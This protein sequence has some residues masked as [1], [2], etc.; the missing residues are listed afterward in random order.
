MAIRYSA[1]VHEFIRLNYQLYTQEELANAVNEKFGTDFT[2]LKMKSYFSN[3]GLKSQKR[4]SVKSRLY[5]SEVQDF[6]RDNV[7]G[8]HF[9]DLTAAINRFFGTNYKTSQIRAY[10]KNH[11]L[12]NGIDCRIKPGSVPYTKGKTWDEYMD[13]EH[14]AK[15]RQTCY[16]KGHKPANEMKIGD[17]AQTSDGYLIIKVSNV[18]SQWER[19]RFIHKMVYE[20]CFG[21]IPEG[22]VVLFKDGDKM[23]CNPENL[24]LITKSERAVLNFKK[25]ISANPDI[26]QARIT[27]LRIQ[28]KVRDAKKEKVEA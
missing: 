18:G 5:P 1:E 11:N 24:C 23:N 12:V 2:R 26:T 9:E 25:L 22:S 16:S 19:W 20:E 8:I 13:K 15:S 28:R 6:I 17:V 27:I 10:C 14:Q 7:S 3:H 21:P 4:A